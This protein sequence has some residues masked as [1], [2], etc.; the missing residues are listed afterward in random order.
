MPMLRVRAGAGFAGVLTLLMLAWMGA[1][2][3]AENQIERVLVNL[4]AG[5]TYILKDLKKTATPEIS[6]APGSHPFALECPQQGVC[7]VLGLAAGRGSVRATRND[8]RTAV[9]E[10]RV[11]ALAREGHPLEPAEAVPRSLS[12]NFPADLNPRLQRENPPAA[13]ASATGPPASA[14]ESVS[15][16]RYARN[17]SANELEVPPAGA[18]PPYYPPPGTISLMANTSRLLAFGVPLSRISIADSKIADVSVVGASS[19]MLVGHHPGFT[20]L[21]VWADNGEYWQ[22]LVRVNR[23]GA[24][25]VELNVVVAEL[26]RSKLETHGV[27]ISVALAN[28]GIS[29]VGLPGTVATPYS[30]ST[31]LTASGGQGT[32]I[33]LPPT[34]VLPIG[35]SLIPLLLSQNLTY[36]VATQNGQATTNS[37]LQ[38]L[39]EH[40]LAKILAEPLLIAES[41]QEAD[42]LSGGEIPIVIS[43]ALNTSVVFKQFGTSV[44]FVPT[45]VDP[46]KGLIDLVVKPELSQPDYTKGVQLFGFTVPAFVTRRAETSVR[47]DNNQTLVIAGLILNTRQSQVRKVP[48]LGDLPY[49]GS[50]FRHTSWNHV[51]SELVMTVTPRIVRPIPAGARVTLPTQRGP[52]TPGEIRTRPLSQPNVARPRL[53]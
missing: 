26:N 25:E 35:G 21:A 31:N 13:N 9:F 3:G 29:V 33:P 12:N 11:S 42:F 28:A 18:R 30:P 19:L 48:Y 43:Q 37:F 27:D 41:G 16:L 7:Y 24:Q 44:K 51:K 52:I 53:R 45:V 50:L 49:L 6:F 10:I 36:A 4:E 1:A 2:A 23:G 32:I 17:P 20:T 8:G 46:E 34:G 14:K 40:D 39:E 47:L 5:Q 22:R 15:T 38:L